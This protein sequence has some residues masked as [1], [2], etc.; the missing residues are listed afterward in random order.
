M[1]RIPSTIP[2]FKFVSSATQA[3]ESIAQAPV[4]PPPQAPAPAFP[5]Q[6]APAFPPQAPVSAP[7][8][9]PVAPVAVQ[10]QL[11]GDR[12]THIA[13]QHGSEQAWLISMKYPDMD[14]L[15]WCV[16]EAIPQLVEKPEIVIFGKVGHQNRNV[17]FFSDYSIGYRYSGQLAKSIPLSPYLKKLLA[18]VNAFT[19]SDFNG[20]LVNQYM[21]G[22]DSIGAHSDD[23]RSLGVNGVVAISVGAERTFRIRDKQT[24]AIVCDI[25]TKSGYILWMGG[26]FQKVYTHEIPVQKKITEMRVSF[27]FRKHLE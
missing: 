9:A 15:M 2:K 11:P 25:P 18:D 12:Q 20:I 24:K 27:T 22:S 17:G 19:G 7:Q 13:S 16:H 14:T 3:G 4:F 8:A 1:S 6:A 21:N 5:P 10:L 23:E 26:C